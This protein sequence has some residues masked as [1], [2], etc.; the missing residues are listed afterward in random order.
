MI[1][2]QQFYR[3]I[4]LCYA[5]L[6]VIVHIRRGKRIRPDLK[7]PELIAPVV[8]HNKIA[9]VGNIF[10]QPLVVSAHVIAD[11]I[12]ADADNNGTESR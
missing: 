3:R 1:G 5:F 8:L 11:C 7:V 10:E 6:V 4:F 9:S 12:G 2:V